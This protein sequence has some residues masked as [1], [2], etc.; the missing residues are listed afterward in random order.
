M[1]RT[2]ALGIEVCRLD[3]IT[4]IERAHD[5]VKMGAL[6]SGAIVGTGDATALV[7]RFLSGRERECT[8]DGVRNGLQ[9]LAELDPRQFAEWIGRGRDPHTA[10][11]VQIVA[12]GVWG[13]EWEKHCHRAPAPGGL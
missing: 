10:L 1:S 5:G 2:W 11:A 3:L 7:T 13:T 4:V 6:D 9:L 8:L 12:M